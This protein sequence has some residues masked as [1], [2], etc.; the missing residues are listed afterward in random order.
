MLVT[1]LWR[2]EVPL[3]RA[4][5]TWAVLVAVPINISATIGF[6]LLVRADRPLAAF[7]VGHLISLPYNL[8]ALIV[9]WRA[10]GK[11]GEPRRVVIVT[12]MIALVWLGLLSVI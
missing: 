2:G 6:F 8:F 10:A 7:L 11:S 12:R 4:L 5:W 1:R 9:V 3:E